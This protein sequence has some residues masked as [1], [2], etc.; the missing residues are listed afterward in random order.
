MEI[1]PAALMQ[2]HIRGKIDSHLIAVTPAGESIP[3][4]IKKEREKSDE[5]LMKHK[6]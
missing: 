6:R 4:L 3:D 5:S 1:I 2:Q